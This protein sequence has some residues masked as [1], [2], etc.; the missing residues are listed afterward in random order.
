MLL[1]KKNHITL[2]V[3][4]LSWSIGASAVMT[5]SAGQIQGTVPILK[6]VET[7]AT[8]HS[9]SFDNDHSSGSV[10]GLAPGDKVTLKYN[11]LDSEGDLD[12]SKLSIKWFTTI[13]GNG[14]D[15]KILDN[16]GQDTYTISDSDA[17]RYLG[18][19]ITEQTSTGIPSQGETITVKDV[20]SNS[21]DDNIPDGPIIGGTVSEM[22]VDS[23]A[24]TVNLIG[25][26]TQLQVGHNYSFKIWYDTNKNGQWDQGELD[27]SNNYTYK[28]VFDGESATTKTPGG[29]AVSSTDNSDLNIP[30]LN[31]EASSVFASAGADGVQGY[32]LRVDYTQIVQH[33]KIRKLSKS[34]Q[35]AFMI[36]KLVHTK[37]KKIE[38]HQ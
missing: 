31:T 18:A 23:E 36:K 27:A 10:D 16:D 24:P 8:D 12:S 34:N 4:G 33:T 13:D 25:S 1:F 30:I 3:L 29:Y 15:K 26:N 21:P 22:I 11:F 17:G 28:W 35:K 20:A 37:H 32:A 6:G 5:E 2:L 19:E 14:T 7:G 9:V 38:G